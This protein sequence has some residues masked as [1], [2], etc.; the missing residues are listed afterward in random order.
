MLQGNKESEGIT[1]Q[2]GGLK[3]EFEMKLPESVELELIE[4]T[5]TLIQVL[6][7]LPRDSTLILPI[8]RSGN[9]AFSVF[10]ATDFG[11]SPELNTAQVNIGRE[12]AAG[13]LPAVAGYVRLDKEERSKDRLK[14][15]YLPWLKRNAN[16][17]RISKEI[18]EATPENLNN[19]VVVDDIIQTGETIYTTT[20][21]I[22][23]DALAG[24]NYF[25]VSD[26][27]EIQFALDVADVKGER[28]VNIRSFSICKN[29]D[30][31]HEIL[32]ENFSDELS[33]FEGQ[34]REAVELLL[35][36]IMKGSYE[37][38]GEVYPI[39]SIE[40]I[41]EIEARIQQIEDYKEVENILEKILELLP[42]NKLLQL[43]EKTLESLTLTGRRLDLSVPKDK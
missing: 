36:E 41:K 24:K 32:R 22:I 31:K 43:H 29:P 15:L 1:P 10:E 8:G 2:E 27:P 4:G 40:D 35:V 39:E 25:P 21:L 5:S 7:K 34:E 16:V 18:E 11:S 17:Q 33:Q 3:Q 42:E 20:P 28:T 19:I 9:L 12:T 37:H 14:E 38:E 23:S 13:F 26:E 6:S 30:W